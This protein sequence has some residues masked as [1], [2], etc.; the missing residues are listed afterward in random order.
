MLAQKPVHKTIKTEGAL[1]VPAKHE[2]S[3]LCFANNAVTPELGG[4]LGD[5]QKNSIV[6]QVAIDR[7]Q[8][9]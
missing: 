9:S 5:F 4:K 3:R 6:L 2:A 1:R 7:R 8:V